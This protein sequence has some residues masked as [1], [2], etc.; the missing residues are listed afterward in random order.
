[1]IS[2]R[3]PPAPDTRRRLFAKFEFLIKRKVQKLRFEVAFRA[4]GRRG[5]GGAR[6]GAPLKSA[7]GGQR[8]IAGGGDAR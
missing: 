2:P 3:A 8:G 1:D 5:A 7:R 6:A 4:T